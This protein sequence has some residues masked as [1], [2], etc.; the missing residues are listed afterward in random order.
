MRRGRGKPGPKPRPHGEKLGVLLGVRLRAEELHRLRERSG[1]RPVASV[2]RDLIRDYLEGGEVAGRLRAE[3]ERV[4][5][6]RAR[7]VAM[8]EEIESMRKRTRA[9]IAKQKGARR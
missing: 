7:L 5:E 2:V 9:G 1:S 6:D 3:A 8:L 4:R